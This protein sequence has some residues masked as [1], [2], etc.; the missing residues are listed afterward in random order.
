MSGS[1]GTLLQQW[2]GICSDERSDLTFMIAIDFLADPEI[3]LL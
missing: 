2:S 1:T 3:F